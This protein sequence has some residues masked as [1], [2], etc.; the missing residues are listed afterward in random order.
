MS[1]LNLGIFDNLV[2]YLTAAIQDCPNGVENCSN[3]KAYSRYYL[4]QYY[5]PVPYGAKGTDVVAPFTNAIVELAKT[6]KN[7]DVSTGSIGSLK[8]IIATTI[9]THVNGL[10]VTKIGNNATGNINVTSPLSF[11]LIAVTDAN[12]N[13]VQNLK[14]E[15]P[16]NLLA[17]ITDAINIHIGITDTDKKAAITKLVGG[18]GAFDATVTAPT[19]KLTRTDPANPD[20]AAESKA[21][22]DAMIDALNAQLTTWVASNYTTP[23]VTGNVDVVANALR[24]LESGDASPA[25]LYVFNHFFNVMKNDGGNWRVCSISDIDTSNL[26]NFRINAKVADFAVD[27]TGTTHKLPMIVGHLPVLSTENRVLF[28]SG[29]LAVDSPKNP[30]LLRKIFHFAYTGGNLVTILPGF[31]SNS[32]TALQPDMDALMRDIIMRDSTPSAHIADDDVEKIESVLKGSWKRIGKDT[33]EHKLNDGTKVILKPGTPNFDS[34]IRAVTKCDAIGFGNDPAKCADFL[35]KVA[36]NDHKGLAQLALAMPEDVVAATVANLHPKFAIA[37]LKS[38]GF[39]RKMCKDKV[40]GRQLVKYQRVEEWLNGFVNTHFED[41]IIVASIK[42]NDR[43][44]NFLDL[45]AQLVNANPSVL[46]DSYAGETEESRGEVTVPADLAARKIAAAKS[47]NSGKPVIGW[48]DIQSNMNKVYGSF[49]KGLTFDGLST[50]SPFGM[51]N[52]FPQMSLLTGA[53][54]VRGSTW[55]SMAGGGDEQKVFLQNHDTGLEYSRNIG[56][57]LNELITNLRQNSNKT[58]SAEEAKSIGA[59]LEQFENLEHELFETAWNI[60]KYSQLL[61]VVEAENTS[62]II[63]EDHVKRYVEKYN[64]LL[65]RYERTGNSFNTLISLLKDCCDGDNSGDCK[66]L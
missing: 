42:G 31:D 40:A 58:L 33:W 43:L 35:R 12:S 48:N 25:Q 39:H 20:V 1:N 63:T 3:D 54:I 23:V 59:K 62:E 45:L 47:K 37:I 4:Q 51:D 9:K 55:G 60:Q 7:F 27:G 30:F 18:A 41:P 34:E 22:K 11:T 29:S 52:L 16:N 50:N 26:V 36:L 53:P 38:F 56:K 32:S 5:T 6:I 19:F 65:N 46:N 44:K 15:V 8:S 21:L 49:S 24:V 17:A 61:K 14:L 13:E 28:N 57:I 10:T 64:H 2:G 66:T